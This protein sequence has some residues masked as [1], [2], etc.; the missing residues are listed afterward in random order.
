MFI[1]SALIVAGCSKD[2]NNGDN[3]KQIELPNQS[4]QTQNIFADETSGDFTFNAKSNW[5]ATV[6]ENSPTKASSVLWL[7]LLLNGTETYS[8]SAGAINLTIELDPNHSGV[9][10]SAYI[11]VKSGNDEITITVT[12]NKVTAAGKANKLISRIISHDV[13]DG[14]D[15]DRETI[16][17]Y[18]SKGRVKSMTTTSEKSTSVHSYE[19][20]YESNTIVCKITH[21]DEGIIMQTYQLNSQ[22]Y[23]S[24]FTE[25]PNNTN[26][27]VRTVTTFTYSNDGYLSNIKEQESNEN[28]D[29]TFN[30]SFTWTDG[31]FTAITRNNGVDY[32]SYYS[33]YPN[34]SNLD[35][36]TI[37]RDHLDPHLS[38]IGLT[39]KRAKNLVHEARWTTE[40]PDALTRYLYDFDGDG[41]VTAIYMG[42]DDNNKEKWYTIT[43][44]N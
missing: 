38:L 43:Y 14:K 2:N 31:N 25:T 16:F 34:S 20:T 13:D 32:Y 33:E 17:T 27:H 5:T 21:P 40:H 28:F 12:Q 18:D 30:E 22:G 29:K 4:E 19:Y 6:T 37:P 23:I 44:Q 3:G 36:A 39:G 10:R 11:T 15:G 7:R 26:G 41:Y 1:L 35:L 24:S 42:W 8:G 9:E